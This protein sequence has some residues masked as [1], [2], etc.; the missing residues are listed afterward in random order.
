MR[1]GKLRN[2]VVIE[3]DDNA[4]A[5]TPTQ[6]AHG[7]QAV[8][9][10]EVAERWGDDR[11]LSGRELFRAQ[12]VAP[13]ATGIVTLR[14]LSWL[15]STQHR[16]RIGDRILGIDYLDDVGGRHEQHDVYYRE[17]V[18]T[19]ADVRGLEDG[20]GERVLEDGN[21]RLLG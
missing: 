13:E 6:N 12:Q 18:T 16:L 17:A 20:T 15:S 9:W 7:E 11:H 5:T 8:G 4:A 14:Y 3:Q 21:L 10:R 1:V 19:P 2:R